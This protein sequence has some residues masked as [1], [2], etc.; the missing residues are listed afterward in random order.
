MQNRGTEG[1]VYPYEGTSP[2]LGRNVF[3]AP[4]AVVIG[5]VTVGDDSSIWFNCTVRGDVHTIRIGRETNIQDNSMLHVTHDTHPLVIGDR[6]T[7]GHSVKLHGCTIG[8]ETLIGIGAIVLD[9]AVVEPGSMI[10]AGA[11]VTPGMVVPAGMIV[12]GVPA[13]VL[14]PLTTAERDDL[15]ASAARYVAYAAK[16]R[17]SL[18]TAPA[19]ARESP[20]D[21]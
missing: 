3:V 18:A 11:L 19:T 2:S 7:C 15:A 16:M 13:R 5:D 20:L 12:A 17:R 1:T 8:E 10:A 14:R 9:G 21:E 4:G 6:V